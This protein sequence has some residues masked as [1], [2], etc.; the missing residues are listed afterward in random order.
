M[1]RHLSQVRALIV[2]A[3]LRRLADEAQSWPFGKDGHLWQQHQASGFARWLRERADELEK[4][5]YRKV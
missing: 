1:K 2:K 5:G 3:E 4:H